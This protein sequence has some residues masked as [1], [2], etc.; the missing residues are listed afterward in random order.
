MRAGVESSL[1]G[2]VPLDLDAAG[3]QIGDLGEDGRADVNAVVRAAH[4]LVDDL[5]GR[6]LAVVRD[7]DGLAAG[8]GIGRKLGGGERDDVVGARVLHTAGAEAGLVVGQVAVEGE[9]VADGHGE[10]GDDLG[11]GHHFGGVFLAFVL[12]ENSLNFSFQGEI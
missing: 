2:V 6:R 5:G 3:G 11:D 1:R 10:G 7:L 12:A 4:A 9:G 8:V